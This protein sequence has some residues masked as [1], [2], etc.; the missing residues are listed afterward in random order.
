ML[1]LFNKVEAATSSHA[2]LS[3]MMD[4]ASAFAN[5][6]DNLDHEVIEELHELVEMYEQVRMA[7][8]QTAVKLGRLAMQ[9]IKTSIAEGD[10]KITHPDSN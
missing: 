7:Y 10:T 5:E 9:V 2:R 8:R 1:D 6:H 4:L 3:A